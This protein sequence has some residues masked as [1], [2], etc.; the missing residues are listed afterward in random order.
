M[1]HAA[2]LLDKSIRRVLVTQIVL[3]LISAALIFALLG[4]PQA[5]AAIYGGGVALIGTWLLGRRIS[6]T[7]EI[8]RQGDTAS[9]LGLY[10]GVLPKFIV[11]LALLAAGMGWFKLAP[12][13]L[14]VAFVVAQLG[15]AI[16]LGSVRRPL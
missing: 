13:P 14:I 8:V 10:A 7:P 1:T 12:I 15:F 6:R 5:G 9:Q 4:G 11:T 3:T 16:N 2:E